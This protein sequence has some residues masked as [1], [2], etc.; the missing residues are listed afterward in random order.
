MFFILKFIFKF[1]GLDLYIKM[2]IYK[3]IKEGNG[4]EVSNLG[5][6]RRFVKST[7]M[8][9]QR[10]LSLHMKGYVRIGMGIIGSKYVHRL[11]AE[12]FLPN[13]DN[14]PHVNHKN[15]IKSD[16]RVENLEWC[17]ID[18]N[19][20]HSYM[21]LNFDSRIPYYRVEADGSIIKGYDSHAQA[22]KDGGRRGLIRQSEYSI[23]NAISCFK[24]KSV[25]RVVPYREIGSSDFSKTCEDSLRKV[26]LDRIDC[27]DS[28]KSI[29]ED[30]PNLSYYKISLV[31]KSR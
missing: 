5:N 14:K 1:G 31:V 21:V 16:N 17:T 20:E 28:I 23:E 2:E 29:I 13:P 15:G 4:Y 22:L 30:Y 19:N 18:E 6:V 3:K 7:G 27:G 24:R 25:V 11:V 8:Y 26:I 9:K 12:C 10:C